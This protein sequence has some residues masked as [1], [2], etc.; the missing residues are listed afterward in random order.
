MNIAGGDDIDFDKA[1]SQFPDISLDGEG[2]FPSMATPAADPVASAPT[3]F[4][5]DNF[6]SPPL[7]QQTSVKVTGDDEIEKFENEF[8]DIGPVCVPISKIYNILFT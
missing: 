7:E 1:A 4:S 2:D 3:G 5:F 8:P 6:G